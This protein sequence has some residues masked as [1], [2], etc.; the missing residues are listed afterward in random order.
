MWMSI[1]CT[2]LEPTLSSIVEV[3]IEVGDEVKSWKVEPL[4]LEDDLLFSG[5]DYKALQH[6]YEA[7]NPQV[8]IVL[9]EYKGNH[10]IYNQTALQHSG[11]SS[12]RDLFA[13]AISPQKALAQWVDTLEAEGDNWIPVG[14]NVSFL[15]GQLRAWARRVDKNCDERLSHLIRWTQ[16]I[17]TV[18]FFK[19]VAARRP[20]LGQEGF[21][22]E[23]LASLY[24]CVPW[25]PK[26]SDKLECLLTLCDTIEE[27]RHVPKAVYNR[28]PSEGIC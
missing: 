28:V 4:A 7:R 9:E 18:P 15:C 23:K 14:H 21:S 11:A 16:A 3:A 13:D 2:C 5:V 17:D 10:Y 1:N 26:A 24:G 22:L 8:P 20:H 6:A 19:V 12:L 27:T 25:S